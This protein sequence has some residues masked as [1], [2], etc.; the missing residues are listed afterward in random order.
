MS[1]RTLSPSSSTC[2]TRASTTA[3]LPDVDP[4][5]LM[6]QTKRMR[7]TSQATGSGQTPMVDA[8]RQY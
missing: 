3:M 5:P 6:R 1:K 7:I 8:S 2:R 4:E